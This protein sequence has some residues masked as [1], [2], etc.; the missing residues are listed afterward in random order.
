MTVYFVDQ[1]K[2]GVFA[3]SFDK[4]H[5]NEKN[6]LDLLWHLHYFAFILI[7]SKNLPPNLVCVKQQKNLA[8]EYLSRINLWTL[9]S[10][11]EI[12]KRQLKPKLTDLFVSTLY[13]SIDNIMHIAVPIASKVS[14]ELNPKTTSLTVLELSTKPTSNFVQYQQYQ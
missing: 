6:L 11:P 4:I 10:L 7:Y 5:F 3:I 9:Y 2:N 1:H 13:F 8:C 14:N 12:I